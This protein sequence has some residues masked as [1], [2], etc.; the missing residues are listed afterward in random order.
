MPKV[1]LGT[2]VLDDRYRRTMSHV[3]VDTP[4][5]KLCKVLGISE[6][7]LYDRKRRPEYCDRQ[8][9]LQMNRYLILL[10]R[11]RTDEEGKDQAAPPQGS[12]ERSAI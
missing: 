8:D 11:A 2:Q 10:G 12:A 7:C 4:T 5:K 6:S 1:N 3:L 9:G